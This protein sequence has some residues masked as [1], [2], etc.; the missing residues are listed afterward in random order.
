MKTDSIYRL[1]GLLDY[2]QAWITQESLF[3]I[4]LWLARRAKTPPVPPKQS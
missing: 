1:D 4:G 3:K 2:Q